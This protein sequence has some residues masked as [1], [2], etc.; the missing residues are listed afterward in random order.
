MWLHLLW[1]SPDGNILGR[2]D[3]IRKSTLIT[4]NLHYILCILYTLHVLLVTFPLLE[5]RSNTF[6]GL[7]FSEIKVSFSK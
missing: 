5:N 3:Y 6:E 2:L 7:L 4:F 1:L